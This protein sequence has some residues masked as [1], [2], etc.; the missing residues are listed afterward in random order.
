MTRSFLKG[1]TIAATL[2]LVAQTAWSIDPKLST[3]P[4]RGTTVPTTNDPSAR[5]VQ[6]GSF[7]T[8]A[9]QVSTNQGRDRLGNVLVPDPTRFEYNPARPAAVDTLRP[10]PQVKPTLQ[11]NP[12]LQPQPLPRRAC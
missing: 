9:T 1:L 6:P 8:P 4:G 3:V 5:L 11:L 7:T 12:S 2:T 10:A